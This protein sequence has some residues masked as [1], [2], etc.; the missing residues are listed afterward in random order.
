[1]NIQLS[2]AEI[3]EVI[4][5]TSTNEYAWR[6]DSHISI[7]DASLESM[8]MGWFFCFAPNDAR[9]QGNVGSACYASHAYVSG[10]D[11]RSSVSASLYTTPLRTPTP[12]LYENYSV[13]AGT[14]IVPFTPPHSRVTT[15]ERCAQGQVIRQLPFVDVCHP[16]LSGPD[17]WAIAIDSTGSLWSR[18]TGRSGNQTANANA[19]GLGPEGQSMYRTRRSDWTLVLGQSPAF[20]RL[21]FKAITHIAQFTALALATNGDLYVSGQVVNIG[22]GIVRLDPT[23]ADFDGTKDLSYF[24]RWKS[25]VSDVYGS[26]FIQDGQVKRNIQGTTVTYGPIYD[27][28]ISQYVTFTRFF[29]NFPDANVYLQSTTGR[30]YRLETSLPYPTS[31]YYSIVPVVID[32]NNAYNSQLL[33]TGLQDVAWDKF[34]FDVNGRVWN[35]DGGWDTFA[36][37]RFGQPGSLVFIQRFRRSTTLTETY[38]DFRDKGDDFYIK[39]DGSLWT[40]GAV[41]TGFNQTEPQSQANI[42]GSARFDKILDS[43]ESVFGVVYARRSGETFDDDG[44]RTNSLPPLL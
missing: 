19:L 26:F 34:R 15:E 44:N 27:W 40:D 17:G 33:H 12:L 9:R 14:V 13:P 32:Q 41:G 23:G 8:Q 29:R 16:T 24:T 11:V 28:T 30:C 3:Q 18:G 1:M 7:F 21:S 35:A 25:G 6:N 5:Y 42:G 31:R 22:Q 20:A 43:G 38:I 4:D 10:A 2:D 36:G 39:T 37:S